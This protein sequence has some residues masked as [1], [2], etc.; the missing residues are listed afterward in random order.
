LALE[1]VRVAA[2]VA[3]VLASAAFALAGLD[4]LPSLLKGAPPG[5][6]LVS[7][8][9]ELRSLSGESIA[10][11]AHFPETVRSRPSR[12]LVT[13]RQPLATGLVFAER[14]SGD[15]VL[16]YYV[17]LDGAG[18]ISRLAFPATELHSAGIALGGAN[19]TVRRL[20]DDGGGVWHELSWDSPR[21]Q[22]LRF[23][24]PIEE[25]LKTA[26]SLERQVR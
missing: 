23:K 5:V 6:R 13:R 25:L 1:T 11:P 4:R 16:H 17:E 3:V 15:M 12:I 18:N 19:A 8:L 14:S 24:G 26:E 9:E 10:L 2:S 7:S 20:V 22:V 21:R